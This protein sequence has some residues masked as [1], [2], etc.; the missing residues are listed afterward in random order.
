[1]NDEVDIITNVPPDQVA[2]ISEQG[3]CETR[4]IL[5]NIFHVLYFNSSHP[6]MQ[7]KSFR[8][9]LSLAIDRP[10]LVDALWGGQAEV[11]PGPSSLSSATSTCQ[12][13][14]PRI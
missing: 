9:A 3:C 13:T 6:L 7:D 2:T 12:T 4:N 5:S 8:H 10:L 11:P 14:G 1:V